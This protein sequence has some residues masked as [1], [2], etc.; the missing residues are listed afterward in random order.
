MTDIEYSLRPA[1]AE[2]YGKRDCTRQRRI[3]AL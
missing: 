3:W 2:G 1:T